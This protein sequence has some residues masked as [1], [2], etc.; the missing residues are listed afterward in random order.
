MIKVIYSLFSAVFIMINS[1]LSYFKEL[2][3]IEIKHSCAFGLSLKKAFKGAFCVFN[4]SRYRRSFVFKFIIFLFLANIPFNQVYAETSKARLKEEYDISKRFISDEDFKNSSDFK[5]G[6]V[7]F[8][9]N[10]DNYKKMSK[11]RIGGSKKKKTLIENTFSPEVQKTN[12]PEYTLNGE[13]MW[14]G[15]YKKINRINDNFTPMMHYTD[16]FIWVGS[17]SEKSKYQEQF[18]CKAG[19]HLE[20]GGDY[21][22]NDIWLDDTYA[23]VKL[24]AFDLKFG[25]IVETIGSGDNIS[26]IDILNPKRYHSGL[27]GDYMKTKKAVPMVKS[28]LYL[29]KNMNFETHI[30][31]V[32]Q[33]SE[34]ANIRGIWATG[35]QKTLAAAQLGGALIEE[36]KIDN[37]LSNTQ[38]HVSFNNSF[39]GFEF[40][41]HYF[42]MI[43]NVPIV[44]P[45]SPQYIKLL[46]PDYRGLGVDGNFNLGGEYLLRYEMMLYKSRYVTS[47]DNFQVGVPY[48]SDQVA[49]LLG[50]DRTFPNSLYVNLQGVFTHINDFFSRTSAQKYATEHGVALRV[51]KGYFRDKLQA[52]FQGF[53]NLKTKEYYV[54]SNFEYRY[55]DIVKYI[56]G[57]NYFNG[58]GAK[59]GAISEFYD[60]SNTFITL[61]LNW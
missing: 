10:K 37:G 24:G 31:P 30:M 44:M 41:T 4:S 38:L 42:K 46:Y 12:K 29:N 57:F 39:E 20:Q 2:K 11:A 21:S 50:I 1:I 40:R 36:Q 15:A 6:D 51:Q 56:I 17:K 33:K 28:T 47:Y 60:S 61:K 14:T 5:F 43:E 9:L 16:G 48:K 23:K 32:F 22:S 34:L 13:L 19:L 53:D 54:K 49:G 59:I 3:N 45:N 55:S 27:S 35:L 8:E 25:N 26:F 18:F 52:E 7:D 58:P